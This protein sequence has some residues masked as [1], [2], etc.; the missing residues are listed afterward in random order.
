M[1]ISGTTCSNNR[2][3]ISLFAARSVLLIFGIHTVPS[4]PN[5]GCLPALSPTSDLPCLRHRRV[6]ESRAICGGSVLLN[7]GVEQTGS[8]SCWAGKSIASAVTVALMPVS[9]TSLEDSWLSTR[10]GAVRCGLEP[11]KVTPVKP[12]GGSGW[13]SLRSVPAE[14]LIH[15]R[16]LPPPLRWPELF[17]VFFFLKTLPEV[18][19]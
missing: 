2:S 18:Q 7:S 10:H 12:R 4:S 9:A 1:P 13:L 19:F 6:A 17:F 5:A 8:T 14:L 16:P 3:K 11:P 15:P